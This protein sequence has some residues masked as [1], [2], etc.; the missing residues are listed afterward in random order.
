MVKWTLCHRQNLN[1]ELVNTNNARE[2]FHNKLKSGYFEQKQ[3]RWVDIRLDTLLHVEADYYHNAIFN[4]NTTSVNAEFIRQTLSTHQIATLIDTKNICQLTDNAFQLTSNENVY[5]IT[6]SATNC[7]CSLRCPS[8]LVCMHM[9]R[10]NCPEQRGK[11][12]CKHIH[13]IS[14]LTNGNRHTE[15]T[16]TPYPVIHIDEPTSSKGTSKSNF[17]Y[18][19]SELNSALEE[20]AVDEGAD[21]VLITQMS[22]HLNSLKQKVSHI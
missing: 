7:P 11:Y 6:R 16:A 21:E 3:N 4:N 20:M 18:C 17:E 5:D 8:C 2:S 12:I 15:D 19:C 9:F 1:N 22:S 14:M 10:C 13:R